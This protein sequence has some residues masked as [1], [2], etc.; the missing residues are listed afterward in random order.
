MD[1]AHGLLLTCRASFADFSTEIKDILYDIIIFLMK[2]TRFNG[3][4]V[5]HLSH[6]CVFSQDSAEQP[7]YTPVLCD[8]K[9]IH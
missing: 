3:R 9:K 7:V 8:E 4:V 1:D 5:E 2:L 6:V